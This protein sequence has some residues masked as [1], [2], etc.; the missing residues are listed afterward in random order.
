[1]DPLFP[2]QGNP[3]APM[4]KDVRGP[5][6][7][8]IRYFWIKPGDLGMAGE[9]ARIYAEVIGTEADDEAAPLGAPISY[10][11]VGAETSSI[12]DDTGAIPWT[13]VAKSLVET[14]GLAINMASWARVGEWA[15]ADV[16]R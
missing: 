14:Y 7:R 8:V 15:R 1:M 12:F 9:S 2:S 16:T 3:P 10:D 11:V 4:L 5:A 13:N 6:K